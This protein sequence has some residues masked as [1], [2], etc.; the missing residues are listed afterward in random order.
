MK[1]AL[2]A[3]LLM[4]C[5]FSLYGQNVCQPG[6]RDCACPETGWCKVW[7]PPGG[8]KVPGK[9]RSN[10]W[11]SLLADADHQQFYLFGMDHGLVTFSN[12]WWA[13]PW[14]DWTKLE[15]PTAEEQVW[16]FLTDCGT[17]PEALPAIHGEHFTLRHSIRA[18]EADA[19]EISMGAPLPRMFPKEG[20]IVVQDPAGEAIH[21]TSCDQADAHDT[22]A[23]TG[24]CL[25]G[26]ERLILRHL[27]RGFLSQAGYSA[28]G[29]AHAAGTV[30]HQACPAPRN[31]N[32]AILAHPSDQHPVGDS[33]YDSKRRR[34]WNFGGYSEVYSLRETWYMPVEGEQAYHWFRFLTPTLQ[35]AETESGGIYD[36]VHD[37]ILRYGGIY[38][39]SALWLLCFAKN[40]AIGCNRENDWNKVE[41]MRGALPGP[42]FGYGR[43]WDSKSAQ[44]L[45][46]GGNKSNPNADQVYAYDVGT[47]TWS[48]LGPARGDLPPRQGF[49]SIAFDPVRGNQGSLTLYAT[50]GLL[51]QF[52]IATRTWSKRSDIL[53][54]A[55]Q[56]PGKCEILNGCYLGYDSE[57]DQ[58]VYLSKPGVPG[59]WILSGATLSKPLRQAN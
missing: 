34:L 52:D 36:S 9:M 30:V 56:G 21:Y 59:V 12:A 2:W 23:T 3:V 46:Y 33:A 1:F 17:G 15:K 54:S 11:A 27:S 32:G 35:P 37:V 8:A 25:A 26:S 49:P 38:T 45:I 39:P 4:F 40:T 28:A 13:M 14:K 55:P 51:Y 19:V 31:M 10:G 53:S 18:E 44:V 41:G 29:Q 16:R 24:N 43:I 47:K 57:H 58:Y 22:P 42:R 6:G 5:P 48:R 7:P 20:T 50:D